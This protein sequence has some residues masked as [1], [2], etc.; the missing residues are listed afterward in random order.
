MNLPIITLVLHYERDIVQARQRARQ[1]AALVGFD[2]QDQTRI[3]T[4]VSEIARNAFCYG[5][6]GHVEFRLEGWTPPQ[7]L[8]VTI[9]DEGPGIRDLESILEG[10]Y[11][12]RSGMGMG[13]IGARRLMDAFEVDSTPGRGTRVVL[14]KLLPRGR[15]PLGPEDVD[16]IGQEL[17]REKPRDA[18]EEVQRQNQE[19]LEA[20]AELTR[21]QEQL[22]TL[23]RELE[24]TNRGVVALYAE[25]DEK[26]DHL[27]RA[28][29]IKTR[30]ISNM[31]HEFRTP[32]NSIQ[33]L[34]GLL[35]DRVDGD[36]NSEQERQVTFIRKAADALAELVNDL[37]DLAKVEAG[38]TVVQPTEVRIPLLF[39]T[40]RGMLRPLLVNESVQLVFDEGQDLPVLY[41]DEGKLSQILRNFISNALK[42]TERGEVRVSAHLGVEGRSVVFHVA[43]TGIGI[44]PEDQERVFQEFSQVEHPIQRRVKGTGLGLPLCRRLAGLLGGTVSVASEVGIGSTFSLEIPIVYELPKQPIVGDW[45]EASGRL[46]VL[47]VEDS[48]E[49]L[50]VYEKYLSASPFGM[51]VART[52]RE[53][54]ETLRLLTPRAI[55]LDILLQGEDAWTLLTEIKRNDALRAVPVMILTTV[56]DRAKAI[57]LGA[58]AFAIKPIDRVT[59]VRTLTRLVTPESTRRV[60]IID[61]DE[62]ARYVMRQSLQGTP[63]EILEARGGFEGLRMAEESLPDLVLLDLSMPDLDGFEVLERL[64]AD[65]STRSIPVII[66][67]SK[68]LDDERQLLA[69]AV[70]R[71]LYKEDIS[72]ERMRAVVE[73]T[74]AATEGR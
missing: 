22:S 55:V 37:L 42:F 65:P 5:Q 39:G 47:F 8:I 53:A 71:V 51:V 49:T 26:A 46:A 20:L 64:E 59:L 21:R 44:A 57:A 58:D 61:D 31:S 52:T 69:Q 15:E 13:I 35:Y 25:L 27:R 2:G 30:F 9:T 41:T 29:E 33:A 17:A 73:E 68:R 19:L 43:D 3:S 32:V 16:R 40:L 67:T 28:D 24:D 4:A 23:N 72:P 62:I 12:S 1:I 11:R 36:L 50:L 18:V 34:A 48:A 6:G 45:N 63:H 38:K 66:V 10:R 74:T 60:L 14:K 7:V 54:R 56:E 70:K